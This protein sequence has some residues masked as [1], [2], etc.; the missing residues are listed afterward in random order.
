MEEPPGGW[1]NPLAGWRSP[2]EDGAAPG[3]IVELLWQDGVAPRVDGG[4]P[5]RTEDPPGSERPDPERLQPCPPSRRAPPAQLPRGSPAFL[6]HC[7]GC[8]DL[9]FF[10]F[11][12]NFKF[13]SSPRLVCSLFLARKAGVL[14]ILVSRHVTCGY[15]QVLVAPG[16][17]RCCG[18]GLSVE[19]LA[20]HTADV[21]MQPGGFFPRAL[22]GKVRAGALVFGFYPEPF[23]KGSC[24]P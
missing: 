15:A 3:R 20:Q 1:R 17:G 12:F 19:L 4:A 24:P 22:F 11:S 5:G 9:P 18:R 13:S 8:L 7:F 14:V 16:S 23:S 6:P 21:E 10:C 2:R